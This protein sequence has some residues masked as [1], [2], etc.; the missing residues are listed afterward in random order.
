MIFEDVFLVFG[1]A[2]IA[3]CVGMIIHLHEN[4]KE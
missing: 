4:H 3:V 1:I 2:W